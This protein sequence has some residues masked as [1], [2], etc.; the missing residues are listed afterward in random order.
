MAFSNESQYISADFGLIASNCG[1]TTTS[2]NTFDFEAQ[3]IVYARRMR[4]EQ[5]LWCGFDFTRENDARGFPGE[6][7]GRHTHWEVNSVVSVDNTSV[8]EEVAA[9]AAVEQTHTPHPAAVAVAA[10]PH[11]HPPDYD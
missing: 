2:L 11:T 8:V 4:F 7:E 1:K 5:N 3:A 6:G 10:N 9:V